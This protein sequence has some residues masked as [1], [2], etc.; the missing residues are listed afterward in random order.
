MTRPNDA[1]I[2]I[3]GVDAAWTAGQPSG[4]ALVKRTGGQWRSVTVA[5]SYCQFYGA[6][7][8]RGIDW[9]A[10]RIPGA[11]PCVRRLF[12]TS[13]ALAG[14]PPDVIT[15]D[16]PV[17][18]EPIT[19]RRCADRLV[20][21]EFGSRWCSALSPSTSRPG[22]VG[23]DFTSQAQS[24][25]FGLATASC[26]GEAGRWLVEVYPHP[27]LLSLLNRGRRVEY[28]AAK[29][30]SYWPDEPL[31]E[32]INR[33]LAVYAAIHESLVR[34]FGPVGFELPIGEHV[35]SLAR[36]KRYEDALDALVCAWV[37][38]LFVADEAVP[39]GNET[40]AVWCPRNVV[41]AAGHSNTGDSHI[42]RRARGSTEVARNEEGDRR[43]QSR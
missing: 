15:V 36:L 4:V 30:R 27:A 28:K 7:E 5:P 25:G 37:G 21:R 22:H 24:L 12:D 19:G 31:R 41:H 3:L 43:C 38:T 10:S 32:R 8:G 13:C 6:A 42:T 39:L 40:A 14:T 34:V 2:T 26:Y 17:A 20:S 29:S 9:E 16:M 35:P 33:L 23:S 18:T 1:E 11:Q